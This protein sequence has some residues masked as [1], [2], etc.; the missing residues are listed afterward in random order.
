MIG[1]GGRD[2]KHELSSGYPRRKCQC[3][4]NCI[5]IPLWISM[6]E[7]SRFYYPRAPAARFRTGTTLIARRSF[8][9]LQICSHIPQPTQRSGA[10][11][12]RNA[13]K[14]I[15]SASTGHFDTQAWHPWPAVQTRCD[16]AA[17]PIRTSKQSATGTSA[18]VAQAAIQGKSSH[19]SHAI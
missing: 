15:D 8:T 7:H 13:L 2:V 18:S 16:T 1:K 14:S 11:T 6:V 19:N 3:F 17:R 12:R 4:I 5:D 9:V 10:T